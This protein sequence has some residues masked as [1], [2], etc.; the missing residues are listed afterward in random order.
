MHENFI[1]IY[2][3]KLKLLHKK[4]APLKLKCTPNVGRNWT[5]F[6]GVYFMSK[7]N[8]EFKLEAVKKYLN[9]NTGY[10][11]LAK[12]LRI[13]DKLLRE[14]VGK[15]NKFG[16]K[17]LEKNNITYDGKFKLNVVE[18]MHK[19]NLSASETAIH[20]NLGC[21]SVVCRWERIYY[22]EGPQALFTEKRGRK[23]NMSKSKNN[24]SKEVEE[25]LIEEVQ[26]LRME[27][28]YLKK[29]QAL[30]QQRNIQQNKK[31]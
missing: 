20:F 27:N 31:K 10:K 13:P 3:I 26:R 1:K 4:Q 29:L 6:G 21:H 15:Y 24:L 14:W 17:G 18:Y 23:L 25:T 30:V 5:T 7:Y 9:G 19:N 11:S 8:K 16:T 12:E 22:E 28:A 2:F